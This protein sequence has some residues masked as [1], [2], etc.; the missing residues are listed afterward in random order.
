[1]ASCTVLATRGLP[2]RF[3]ASESKIYAYLDYHNNVEFLRDFR[4]DS[5]FVLRPGAHYSFSRCF[6]L[7]SSRSNV[8]LWGDSHAMHYFVGLRAQV[9]ASRVN[10][11]EATYASCRPIFANPHSSPAC[12]NFNR[13][14]F[15]RLDRRV[16]LVI[17]SAR[18]F[19]QKEL[20]GAFRDTVLAVHRRGIRVIVLG[21]SLEY[22]E[23]EPLYVARYEVTHDLGFLDSSVRL[24]D[25]LYS[26]DSDARSIF[27]GINEVSYV[28][29]ARSVCQASCPMIV[30]GMPVQYDQGH[31]TAAG[32]RLFV[33]MLWPQILPVIANLTHY[34]SVGNTSPIDTVR[35]R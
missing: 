4:V 20:L 7:S 24:R 3:P 31:L 16:S 5:C 33:R 15:A 11:I 2:S 18:L 26:F 14:V 9:D 29:V 30:D 21:P 27:A 28:S 19:E 25:D 32:S 1:L 6:N 10:L 23:A 17:V 12:D 22:Q 8:V 35:E 13:Q 34:R